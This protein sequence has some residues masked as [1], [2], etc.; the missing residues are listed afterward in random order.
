MTFKTYK[1]AP[2]PFIGQKRFFISHFVKL[3]KDK[4]PNDGENWTII[5]VFGGSGLLAHNAKR[6]LPKARVI[7]NDFD[8]YAQRLQN[9]A[10]TERLRQKLFDLLANA[11][12]ERKLNDQQ[13]KQIIETINQ[14]DGYLDINAIATWILFSGKQ[15]KT[16]DELYQNTFYNT[17]RKTPYK[18]ADGYLDGL[19]ITHESFETL[20]PKFA[21][22]PNTLL[23]LDPPYVFTEQTAYH[24][25]KY[26][27]MVE[28]LT[29]MSLVRPPYIFF[30]S[31]KS[32]LLDYLAY[33]QKHQPHD[34]DRLGGF[35][36]LFL[37]SQVNY[38]KSY[39]DNMIW[40]F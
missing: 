12:D 23:L 1:S 39:Q 16:L 15:A 33:V 34:W 29:L 4:I 2:L 40:K 7:Y 20:I 27:G 38:H 9:I 6:L 21:N 22:Q 17:V 26:F 5:D 32:E 35:D 31:T 36:R 19:E 25:A 13:R 8:G 18:T 10:D 24:Q 3:L 11:E 37:Q 14:F 28:F 30:S